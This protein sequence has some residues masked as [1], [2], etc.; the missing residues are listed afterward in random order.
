MEL[1][2]W[3]PYYRTPHEYTWQPAISFKDEQGTLI[4]Q[5]NYG[6]HPNASPTRNPTVS[7]IRLAS[8]RWVHMCKETDLEYFFRSKNFTAEDYFVLIKVGV[9]MEL[10]LKAALDS[11]YAGAARNFSEFVVYHFDKICIIPYLTPI[12]TQSIGNALVS[13]VDTLNWVTIL[14]ECSFSKDYYHD[15][16]YQI[17]S[18]AIITIESKIDIIHKSLLTIPSDVVLLIHCY[19]PLCCHV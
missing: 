1:V 3:N 17:V 12:M 4:Y 7:Q 10:I 14:L 6:Y 2:E 19:L 16:S 11:N 18:E 13:R 8:S 15:F 9:S 5:S